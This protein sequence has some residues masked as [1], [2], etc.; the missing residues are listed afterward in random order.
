MNRPG[1]ATHVGGGWPCK[2][3]MSEFDATKSEIAIESIEI[4]IH[5]LTFGAKK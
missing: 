4:A 3:E 5:G 2:W 1:T